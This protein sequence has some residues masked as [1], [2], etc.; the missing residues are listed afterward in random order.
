M[1]PI[2]VHKTVDDLVVID[3]GSIVMPKDKVITFLINDLTIKFSFKDDIEGEYRME[4]VENTKSSIHICFVKYN[5]SLGIASRVPLEIGILN[6]NR[7]YIQY[8]VY[9]IGDAKT[10]N[11]TWYIKNESGKINCKAAE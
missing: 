1:E 6:Q 2:C 10:F 4:V 7:L 8:A 9:S 3:S 5:N 11:Y